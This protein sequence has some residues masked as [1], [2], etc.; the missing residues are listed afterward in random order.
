MARYTIIYEA[1]AHVLLCE[2]WT[3]LGDQLL[4]FIVLEDQ[5]LVLLDDQE[6]L[7]EKLSTAL[8]AH[9]G[10]ELWELD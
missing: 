8:L 6:T 7:V 10:L 1:T 5:I 9:K 2:E 3:Q 4:L